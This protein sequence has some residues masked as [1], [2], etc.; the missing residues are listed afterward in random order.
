MGYPCTLNFYENYPF[1]AVFFREMGFRTVLSPESD[2]RSIPADSTDSFPPSESG[3]SRQSWPTA[4]CSGSSTRVSPAFS[5]RGVYYEEQ[6]D[7]SAQNRYNLSH[8]DLVSGK[9]S[10]TM[11]TRLKERGVQFFDPFL[12][13]ADEK[14]L[15]AEL[16]T[17]MEEHFAADR[18]ECAR[19]VR[20]GWEELSR[21][22]DDMKKGRGTGASMDR[23][24]QCHGIVLAGRP[25][26]ADDFVNHGIAALISSYG[27]AVFDR[28]QRGS[29]FAERTV[30]LR[31]YNQWVYHSRLHAAA[32]Y[33]GSRSDL[34][35][36]QLNSFGCGLDAITIDQVHDILSA[37]GK[38][39]T[40]I[41]N[42]RGE[43]SGRSQ[44][45]PPVPVRRCGYQK[46]EA[47]GA[48]GEKAGGGAGSR[49]AGGIHQEDAGTGLYDFC[50]P[51]CLRFLF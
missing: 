49:S 48:S 28:G 19:A 34:D 36:I 47:G 1:W 41:K 35:L 43:Q 42:R 17:F 32:E 14:T 8:G 45:P 30:S 9:T 40:C 11:W 39:Y 23:E 33:V 51:P 16:Q 21:F 22:H 29:S 10:A 26:Q 27:Y 44:N 5:I 31:A 7:A 12:S 38:L 6:K 13:F 2:Q 4:M 50:A 15:C 18:R 25:Y 3:C 37:K 24:H 46:A 20:K